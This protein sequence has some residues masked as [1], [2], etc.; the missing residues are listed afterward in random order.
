MDNT[1]YLSLK[2]ACDELSISQATGRNW[3][4][5]EKLI[6]ENNDTKLPLFTKEYIETLKNQILSG[7][8]N[9]LKS[10]RNKKFVSGN[11]LYNSYVSENCTNISVLQKLLGLIIQNQV[12]LNI[13]NI[14]YLI[15]DAALH[16]FAH[17]YDKLWKTGKALLKKYLNE[18]IV[19]D[20]YSPLIDAL[21]DD[22]DDALRFCDEN[23]LLFNLDYE[24]EPNEDILGLIYISCENIGNRK[25]T[26]S[27]FT[28]TRVVKKLISHLDINPDS[29]VL[30][31]CCG[32]GNFLLQLSDEI[33]FDNIYGGDIDN[34]SVTIA[35]LNMGLKFSKASLYDIVNHISMKDYL[36]PIEGEEDNDDDDF[37]FIIGNPPWG[38]DF[39]E[40]T[41]KS[42]RPLYKTA[43]KKNIE[44]YNVFIECAL[45]HLKQS[46]K[47]SFVLPEAILNVK[48]HTVIREIILESTSI[49]YLE[50][51]G[52]AFDGVQCPCI[53]MQLEKNNQPLSTKGLTICNENGTINIEIERK[54]TP[55]YFSFITTD[56][57]YTILEKIKNI[58]DAKT[59]LNNGDFALGIVTGN[60]K[61]YI[62]DVKTEDNEMVLKGSD[63]CK[64]HI[65]ATDNYIVFKPESFQQVAPTEMY[66]AK[67]KLLYRFICN[68]LVFAYDDKQTLSLNSCNM[69]IPKLEGIQI[70]YI[71][72]ILNS[73][74][75]QFIYKKEFNSL[76]VLR[77]HI[78][79]IPL[80]AVSIEKQNEI[81]TLV[82]T[83]ISGLPLSEANIAYEK[84][85]TMIAEIFGLST[86]EYEVIK[87]AV[88]GENKFL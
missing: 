18:E 34:I 35:R 55:E 56:E 82:D 73:R 3:I 15:A 5:L 46:G 76:K 38:F 72:A 48:A 44:S 13:D 37:D 81:I 79:S 70:K 85:D 68:Q 51:L 10:R 47:L 53:I 87:K 43:A 50:F 16:L 64:Y 83:L 40:Q 84:V 32:T 78:E 75:A 71:L 52:N 60:N 69:V 12:E 4:K 36:I 30:D 14:R 23:A 61:E 80:P 9:A 77:A 28:P 6:P 19:L 33:S 59:L 74:I 65:N 2:E 25:A 88:D 57:E 24:Y 66:R 31:P 26:G 67:E 62:S 7:E 20:K 58:P 54:V 8:N 17:R 63:I 22:K 1:N 42:L 49:K 39:S 29:K 45:M 86:N 41:K 27:Y 21:I 11:S